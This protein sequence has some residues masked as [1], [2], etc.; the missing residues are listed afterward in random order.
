MHIGSRYQISVSLMSNNLYPSQKYYIGQTLV[1]SHVR[2]VLL[3]DKFLGVGDDEII[4]M[5]TSDI[6]VKCHMPLQ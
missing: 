4:S 1:S 3:I 2:L 5:S 6:G